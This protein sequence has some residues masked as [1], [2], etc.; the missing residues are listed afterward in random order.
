MP[1]AYQK[2]QKKIKDSKTKQMRCCYHKVINGKADKSKTYIQKRINGKCKYSIQKGGD[3]ILKSGR[4]FDVEKIAN[5]KRFA[6]TLNGNAYRTSNIANNIANIQNTRSVKKPNKMLDHMK[7]LNE[8]ERYYG[9]EGPNVIHDYE[10]NIVRPYN[11]SS[12]GLPQEMNFLSSSRPSKP[13][14]AWRF[15]NTR[16]RLNTI[17]NTDE[18]NAKE[19]RA[20]KMEANKEI[21][22]ADR[23]F[24][25]NNSINKN[26]LGIKRQNYNSANSIRKRQEFSNNKASRLMGQS[27]KDM[28]NIPFISW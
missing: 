5:S 17:I 1:V 3:G 11:N 15:T 12:Q 14:Q 20:K 2:S 18:M 8:E 9:G 25:E 13:K 26:D 4:L 21:S 10:D 22:K 23:Y 7:K 27:K 28:N 24:G 16:G 19:A 6:N